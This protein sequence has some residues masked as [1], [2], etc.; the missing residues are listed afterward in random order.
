MAVVYFEIIK[1]N[2][3]MQILYVLFC[4]VGLYFAPLDEFNNHTCGVSCS[5]SEFEKTKICIQNMINRFRGPIES[6]LNPEQYEDKLQSLGEY[7]YSQHIDNFFKELADKLEE[8][9]EGQAEQFKKD[10]LV[11]AIKRDVELIFDQSTQIKI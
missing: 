8:F 9:F 2:Y 11:I 4:F 5:E 3:I 7:P 1:Y 10:P 6:I